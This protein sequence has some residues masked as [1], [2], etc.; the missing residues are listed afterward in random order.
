[1]TARLTT[2]AGKRGFR[3]HPSERGRRERVEDGGPQEKSSNGRS[4]GCEQVVHDHVAAD[5]AG[6]ELAAALDEALTEQAAHVKAERRALGHELLARLLAHPQQRRIDERDHAGRAER[7]REDGDLAEA[8]AGPENGDALDVARRVPM[9]DLNGAG[10]H[11][12]EEVAG[13]ALA[14]EGGARC[15]PDLVELARDAGEVFAGE[16]RED[17]RTR[18]RVDELVHG[19]GLGVDAENTRVGWAQPDNLQRPRCLDLAHPS[20]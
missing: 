18:D 11:D 13:L 19:L 1:M 3:R 10:L 16:A 14:D 4:L 15:H 20:A 8:L 17:R 9:Q 6:D 5:P 7:A 2:A 12:V